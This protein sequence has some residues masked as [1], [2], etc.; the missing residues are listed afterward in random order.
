MGIISK[1]NGVFVCDYWGALT[2]CCIGKM[3]F[4]PETSFEV[5]EKKWEAW[6]QKYWIF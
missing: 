6:D 5:S 1:C 4:L 3:F 2:F